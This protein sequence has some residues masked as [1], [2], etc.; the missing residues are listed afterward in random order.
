M[1]KALPWAYVFESH[2]D[3]VGQRR[4]WNLPPQAKPRASPEQVDDSSRGRSCHEGKAGGGGLKE[5]VWHALVTRRQNEQRGARKKPIGSAESPAASLF[6]PGVRA[7][8]RLVLFGGEQFVVDRR[9]ARSGSHGVNDRFQ[10]P[11]QRRELR[12]R[13]KSIKR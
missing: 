1:A 10:Q 11:D 12:L 13:K 8:Q 7:G 9:V 2:E 4:G 3:G 5:R 6:E